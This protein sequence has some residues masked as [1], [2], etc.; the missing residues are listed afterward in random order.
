M[1]CSTQPRFMGFAS[2]FP[3]WLLCWQQAA[4]GSWRVQHIICVMPS[5]SALYSLCNEPISCQDWL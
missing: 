2:L 4:A 3:M 1:G 5:P